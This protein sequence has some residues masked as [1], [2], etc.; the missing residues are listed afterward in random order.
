MSV[1]LTEE[2]LTKLQNKRIDIQVLGIVDETHVRVNT[3]YGICICLYNHLLKGVKPSILTAINKHDYFLNKLKDKFPETKLIFLDEYQKDTIPLRIYTKYGECKMTPASLMAGATP[4]I[5]AAVN[6]TEYFLNQLKDL[7][8]NIFNKVNLSSNYINSK[9]HLV[10]YTKYGLIKSTPTNLLNKDSICITSAIN[11]TEYFI[12]QAKEVHGDK[13]D[14]SLVEYK[15]TKTKVKII[16]NKL[17]HG[18]FDQVPN[19][20]LNNECGCPKCAKEYNGYCNVSNTKEFIEKA[21]LKHGDRYSYENVVYVNSR[22]KVKINCSIHN[23]FYQT[24]ND[25]LDGCGCK[26]CYKL[27]QKELLNNWYYKNWEISGSKSKHFDSFKLYIIKC[28]DDIETFYKIGKTFRTIKDRFINKKDMPYNYEV[29]FSQ[30]GTAQYISKLETIFKKLN[31]EFK[32][33]PSKKF[34]GKYECFSQIVLECYA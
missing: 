10:L 14:Y 30:V 21:N 4:T 6:K 25:H 23:V 18:V 13:Y 2:H 12:N 34:G 5:K 32:Y 1:M 17:D 27:L 28:W 9:N 33:L 22:T 3:K 16:C 7:N 20:H 11:P 8:I 15:N 19:S 26:K 29:T 31:K 24:P